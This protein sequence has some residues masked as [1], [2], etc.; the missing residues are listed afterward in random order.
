MTVVQRLGPALQ[1]LPACHPLLAHRNTARPAAM[2]L[3]ATF[4]AHALRLP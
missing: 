4:L 3:P 2:P 1:Q